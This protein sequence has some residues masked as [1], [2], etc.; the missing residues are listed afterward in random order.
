MNWY[1]LE[2]V[3]AI[4]RLTIL[5]LSVAVRTL[6]MV[7]GRDNTQFSAELTFST[8]QQQCLSQIQPSFEGDTKKLQNPYPQGCLPWAT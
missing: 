2:S 4:Q 6:Q 1:Q 3:I 8:N 5:A 7:E